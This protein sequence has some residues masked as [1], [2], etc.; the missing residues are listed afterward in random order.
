MPLLLFL[1]IL[2][3]FPTSHDKLQDFSRKYF[4]AILDHLFVASFGAMQPWVERYDSM[5]F[6]DWT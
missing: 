4:P 6:W 2:K 1:E 5:S 3:M